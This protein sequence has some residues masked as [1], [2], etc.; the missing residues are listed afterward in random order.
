V[1]VAGFVVRASFFDILTANSPD[2][3]VANDAEALRLTAAQGLPVL[4]THLYTK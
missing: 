3:A 1:G 4:F 2:G